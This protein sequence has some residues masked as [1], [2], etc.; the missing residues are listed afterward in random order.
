M[1]VINEIIIHCAATRPEWMADRKLSEQVKEIHKWHTANG[2]SDIGYHYLIGRDGDLAAAR[3]VSRIGAH[4]KG[5]NTA[6]IGV[7]LIGGH[8]ASA[9]DTFAQHFTPAQSDTLRDFI[10]DM[11]DSFG[12]GLK[13]SGHNQYANKGCPGFRVEPWLNA[14]KPAA[15]P[16]IMSAIIALL[17]GMF[18]RKK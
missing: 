10:D 1:R 15:K 5:H 11:R 8:G 9:D 4:T 13:I 14:A 17:M 2:W 16:S 6:S 3:P 12:D 7:C 18:G